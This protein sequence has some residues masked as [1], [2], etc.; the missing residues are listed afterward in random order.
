MVIPPAVLFFIVSTIPGFFVFLVKLTLILSRSF[1][2]CDG[3]L[4]GN[5]VNIYVV[6]WYDDLFSVCI[7]QFCLTY[8]W[9]QGVVPCY[10]VCSWYTQWC[11]LCSE[12]KWK[13]KSRSENL[14][15]VSGLHG[16]VVVAGRS[17]GRENCSKDVLKTRK[18]WRTKGK[19]KMG[20]DGV[21][22]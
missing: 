11:M 21:I 22:T 17:W 20:L 15:W 5:A 10:A 3:I 16:G 9:S 6:F 7:L 8:S 1:K 19:E 18:Y 4:M 13:R 12:V 14:A 2:N